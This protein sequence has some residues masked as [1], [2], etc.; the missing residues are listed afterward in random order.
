MGAHC[1]PTGAANPHTGAQTTNHYQELGVEAG[2]V[3]LRMTMS[4]DAVTGEQMLLSDN[5][6][7]TPFEG[8]T[9]S[10]PPSV[11]LPPCEKHFVLLN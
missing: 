9:G 2:C 3:E 5:Y 11:V 7:F 6:S 8:M 4:D 1:E 10:A